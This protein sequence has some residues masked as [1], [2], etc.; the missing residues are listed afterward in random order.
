MRL[1]GTLVIVLLIGAISVSASVGLKQYQEVVISEPIDATGRQYLVDI[2]ND[3]FLDILFNTNTRI[4]WYSAQ[5][6]E[7]KSSI[8]KKIDPTISRAYGIG[9]FDGDDEPDYVEAVIYGIPSALYLVYFLSS[10]LFSG[11]DT[12]H[13]A[14]PSGYDS[15]FDPFQN[16][17]YYVIG[18]YIQDSDNN[19]IDEVEIGYYYY[20][21]TCVPFFCYLDE[22]IEVYFTHE[23]GSEPETSATISRPGYLSFY[24]DGLT[25]PATLDILNLHWYREVETMGDWYK[26]PLEISA[27]SDS[28]I[29][30]LLVTSNDLCLE[31]ASRDFEYS[32]EP[33]SFQVS[34]ANNGFASPTLYCQ[35][36]L[37]TFSWA[38]GAENL[39]E[40]QQKEL[41]VVDL[42]ATGTLPVLWR[43]VAPDWASSDIIFA[44]TSSP[45]QVFLS[46]GERIYQVREQTFEKLDSSEV[47]NLSGH[48]VGYK[49]IVSGQAPSLVLTDGDRV[50]FFHF[51]IVTDVDDDEDSPDGLPE[52]FTLAQNYPNPFNPS[53]SISFE[54]P[55][56]SPVTLEIINTLGQSVTTLTDRFY[57]AGTHTVDWNGDDANGHPVASG[58]YFY[59]LTVGDV[60]E[61]KKMVLLK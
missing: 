55:T 2:D 24:R 52:N 45:G 26:T 40:E 42:S 5:D 8:G 57:S 51:D 34:D 27:Y 47:L 43:E 19:G 15:T 50:K 12:V 48:M 35:E 7:V 61:T 22:T 17:Y 10:D 38:G 9:Y 28:Q 11:T 21:E 33:L 23:P 30:D 3:G 49:P 60:S 41:L 20:D 13:V 44:D 36:V 58:L 37:K 14:D 39:C 29:A 18:P 31:G 53:T 1:I 6:A 46:N 16:H 59:R 32:I 56:G 25:E 54:L 4:G